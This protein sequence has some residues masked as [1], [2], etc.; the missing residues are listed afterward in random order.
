MSGWLYVT[1][2]KKGNPIFNNIKPHPYNL[3]NHSWIN[4][5]YGNRVTHI[6]LE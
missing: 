1:T 6:N 2:P 4:V 3:G 5:R